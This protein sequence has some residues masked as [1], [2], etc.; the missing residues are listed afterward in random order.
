MEQEDDGSVRRTRF[1]VEHMY[2]IR[3]DEVVGRKWNVRDVSHGFPRNVALLVKIEPSN[4]ATKNVEAHNGGCDETAAIQAQRPPY[5]CCLWLSSHNLR[6][7]MC[8]IVEA[9]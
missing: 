2:T 3:F 8:G 7:E 1:A 5:F 6:I 9:I 4:L